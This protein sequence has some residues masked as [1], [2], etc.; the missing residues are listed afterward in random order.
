MVKAYSGAVVIADVLLLVL[1]ILYFICEGIYRCFFPVDEK[2]VA[3]E[4]VL[5]TGA[6]HGIGKELALKYAGL[7]ATVVCWDIND[8]NNEETISEI[9]NLGGATAH[10]YKCDVSNREEVIQ[11]AEK[12]KKDV[13]SV[14]ILINNAGI[15]PCRPFLDHTAEDIQKIFNINI[16][17]HIWILQAFLPDMLANNH[18]H[19]VALSSMAGIIGLTNLVPYCATKFAVRGMMEALSE[20]LR[21]SCSAGG[22]NSNIKFT[23][24][25][26]YMVDTGLCKKPKIKFPSL[27][28][29]ISPKE[30]A[31]QIVTAQRKNKS[32]QSIPNYWLGINDFLRNL[33]DKA[34]LAFKDFLDSGVAADD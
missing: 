1:K 21:I 7:G 34:P 29:V 31:A 16:I 4:I 15:M 9:N 19:V 28:A 5:V 25:F 24:I 2:S 20:E 26:P 22:R 30:A 32:V 27:M 18:G 23:T 14:T 10:A 3:G 12:V 13:G 8:V 11:V 6:G 17:S 33:P